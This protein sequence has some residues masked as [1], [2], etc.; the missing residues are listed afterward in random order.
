MLEL[1][2]IL[3]TCNEMIKVNQLKSE[4]VKKIQQQK[5]KKL[6]Q[7]AAK[8]SDYYGELYQGIDLETCRIEDL[9]IV[10][11]K[12]MMGNFDHVVTDKRITLKE[13]KAWLEEKRKPGKLYLRKY[14]PIVTSGSTGEKAIVV[15]C[16]AGGRSYKA[17][18]KLMKLGYKNIFQT[19]FADWKKAGYTI[20]TKVDGT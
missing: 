7:F 9:P 18:R 19:L 17:Y 20:A 13:T 8:H 10:T 2:N 6:I 16:N 15:Y 5:F 11:K 14:L 1:L 12:E 4:Q 3:R